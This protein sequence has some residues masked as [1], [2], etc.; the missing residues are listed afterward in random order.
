MYHIHTFYFQ[1]IFSTLQTRTLTYMQNTQR[2]KRKRTNQPFDYDI[3]VE[4]SGH[5]HYYSK[6]IAKKKKKHHTTA[7]LSQNS[8]PS[9]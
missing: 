4:T 5:T 8:G 6:Q 2:F 7:L 1:N 9:M 3:L